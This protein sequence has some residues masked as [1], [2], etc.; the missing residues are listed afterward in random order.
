MSEDYDVII[1]GGGVS[2]LTLGAILGKAGQRCCIV[3]KEHQAG[4][5]IAGYRRKDFH[6]DTAIHWLNQFGETGI[7]H[8]A[9]SFIDANYK[10]PPRL[11]KIHRYKSANFDVLLESDLDKTKQNF[12][13]QFPDELEGIEK[14]FRHAE[15]LAKISLGMANFVRSQET[16]NLIGKAIFYTRM[17]PTIIPIIKHLRYAGDKGLKRGLSKYFK[18]DEIKD[19]FNSEVDLL[20]C[21]FPLAWAKND[22]YFKTPEGGSVHYVNWLLEQN[23][24]F[25]NEIMLK[26]KAQSVLLEGNKAIGI[27]ATQRKTDIKISSKYVVS[28]SDLPSLYRHLLPSKAISEEIKMKLEKSVMYTSSFTLSV[29]LN[30][31]AEELGFGEEMI[32]LAINNM[33]REEHENS[34][35]KVSK[36]SIIAPSVRDKTICPAGHGV[37]TIYMAADIEKYDFWKTEL[38]DNGERIR[39]EAYY[40]LK[41]EIAEIL[42]ERIENDLDIKLKEHIHF[43][44]TASPYT[45]LRY[46]GNY[47]GT[48]MG[49]RPGKENMQAKVASHHTQVENLLVGG[50]WG[51]LGGGVPM[52]A[53]SAMNTALIILRKEN[54]PQFK[55]LCKFLDG[56]I[57]LNRLNKSQLFKQNS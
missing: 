3:E 52:A 16:M 2:G 55:L 8:R 5:Y 9:F 45:Y 47:R 36:L 11:A 23:K 14:F 42:I 32:S 40:Q 17:L 13:S 4:G 12:I 15:Q 51:E 34:D 21:L 24:A 18:G 31:E 39:S 22:D 26:T 28:A 30:C 38:A 37:L 6:F 56:K 20:S 7:V 44:E 49:T 1:I 57:N 43:Y 29:A 50:H 53:R 27:T 10:K 46:S 41:K 19:I 33:A 48:M 54:R 35:P 25:G